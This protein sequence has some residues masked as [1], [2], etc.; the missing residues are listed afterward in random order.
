MGSV[1]PLVPQGDSSVGPMLSLGAELNNSVGPFLSLGTPPDAQ[2]WAVVVVVGMPG[3]RDHDSSSDH[4][5]AA[6]NS[7]AT[8]P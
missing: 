7:A 8:D 1:G 5:G 2:R 3:F 4:G 6:S